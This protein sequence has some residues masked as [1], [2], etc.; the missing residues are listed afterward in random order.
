MVDTLD[1]QLIILFI[2]LMNLILFLPSRAALGLPNTQLYGWCI[3]L[4]GRRWGARVSFLPLICHPLQCCAQPICQSSAQSSNWVTV[5]NA[6][7]VKV[8]FFFNVKLSVSSSFNK[9][10]LNS[11]MENILQ[12]NSDIQLIN[13]LKNFAISD[14]QRNKINQNPFSRH[15][16]LAGY[17]R[18]NVKRQHFIF[19]NLCPLAFPLSNIHNQI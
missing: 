6:W 14:L 8:E 13:P 7:N 19:L 4:P 3:I 15:F 12:Q 16:P 18:P 17:V 10:S 5:M 1:S 2:V 11:K 9:L